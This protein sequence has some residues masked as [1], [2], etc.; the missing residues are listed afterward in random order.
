MENKYMNHKAFESMIEGVLF[1]MLGI[2]CLAYRQEGAPALTVSSM[3]V[4]AKDVLGLVYI[5]IGYFC[6]CW[7]TVDFNRPFSMEHKDHHK[8]VAA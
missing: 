8:I 7:P 2:F 6:G 5:A 3:A 4:Q 1:V